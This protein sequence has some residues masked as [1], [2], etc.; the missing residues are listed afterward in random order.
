MTTTTRRFALRRGRQWVNAPDGLGQPG[1]VI[2][3][4]L[5]L[6]DNQDHLW[7]SADLDLAL[8]RQ[9][10]LKLAFGISTEVRAVRAA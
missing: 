2:P 7:E 5:T 3:P 9:Q 10:V 8:E 6:A 4:K 1:D